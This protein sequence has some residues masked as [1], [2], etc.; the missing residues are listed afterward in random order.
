MSCLQDEPLQSTKARPSGRK[1]SQWPPSFR[2]SDPVTL[3]TDSCRDWQATS[4]FP[5][6]LPCLNL[7]PQ[8]GLP[9]LSA[10]TWRQMVCDL[11]LLRLAETWSGPRSPGCPKKLIR[12]SGV[13]RNGSRRRKAVRWALTPDPISTLGSRNPRWQRKHGTLHCMLGIVIIDLLPSSEQSPQIL[14]RK[15]K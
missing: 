3:P 7:L 4:C 10:G 9:D 15:R 8:A 12:L 2:L 13:K 11:F 14:D 6:S 1:V 5:A